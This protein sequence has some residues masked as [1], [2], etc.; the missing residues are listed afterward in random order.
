L[1]NFPINLCGGRR[2]DLGM[3]GTTGEIRRYRARE[4]RSERIATDEF[5][6]VVGS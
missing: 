4:R 5:A 6:I 1:R 3:A 2:V